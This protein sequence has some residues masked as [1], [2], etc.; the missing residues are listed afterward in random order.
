MIIKNSL[1]FMNCHCALRTM[2]WRHN[3]E[4]RYGSTHS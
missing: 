2:P 1:Q 4:R 3:W